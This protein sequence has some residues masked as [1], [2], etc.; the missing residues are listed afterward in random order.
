MFVRASLLQSGSRLPCGDHHHRF[1]LPHPTVRTVQQRASTRASAATPAAMTGAGGGEPA[2]AAAAASPAATLARVE[3]DDMFGGAMPKTEIQAS[4]FLK[5]SEAP[6]PPAR[7]DVST[8]AVR[9]TPRPLRVPPHPPR[10]RHQG[11]VGTHTPTHI[12]TLHTHTMSAHRSTPRTT[13]GASP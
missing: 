13:G 1:H 2:A 11:D 10:Q 12:Y 4:S 8:L 9:C 6:V 3:I 7:R 5:V